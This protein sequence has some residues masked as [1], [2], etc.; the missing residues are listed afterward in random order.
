MKFTGIDPNGINQISQSLLSI[1]VNG[2]EQMTIS[3]SSVGVNTSLDVDNTV[4]AREFTGSFSGSIQG[5]GSGLTNIP[6]SSLDGDVTRI[7][8]GNATAS[9]DE[10]KLSI[11]VQT[12]ITGALNV[13]ALVSASAF[14]GDGSQITNISAGAI[15]DIDKLKSGS[16][17][18][19][20]SPNLGL[21]VNVKTDIDS[22]LDV[23]GNTTLDSD[24]SVGGEA[25]ITGDLNVTGR[26]V[27][28]ELQTTF[29][30]SSVIYS[31]GSN[32]FGDAS[33][34]RQEFTGSVH[35][36][37]SIQIPSY[38]S[39]PVSG[40]IGEIYY[41]TSDTNIYRYTSEGWEP[42]AGTSGT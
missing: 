18:A 36:K 40:E 37:D 8:L 39:D 42:A 15:G 33:D 41:N 24:L 14:K 28:T 9:I 5:D 17:E 2:V 7:S 4:T 12:D 10:T 19:V 3:T 1:D 20:I 38:S 27:T 29:I 31:S 11:N 16:A 32:T 13:S 6:V 25:S 23:T 35:I 26:I 34:D 22:T 21:Q 30:S